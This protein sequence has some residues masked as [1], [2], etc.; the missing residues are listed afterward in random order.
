MRDSRHR[1]ASVLAAAVLVAGLAGDLPGASAG[2]PARRPNLVVIVLDDLGY[3]DLGCYGGEIRTPNIDRVAADGMRFARFYN[4]SRCCPTRAALLTGLYPHQVNLGSNGRDLGRNGATIAEL[5][6]AAGYRT[7]MAGKWHL[8]STTPLGGK[9]RGAGH[10]AWLNHHANLDRPFADVRTYPVNRGFERHFGPIWGVVDHFD[11]F[12]LV[13]G[14]EPVKAVP[15]GFYLTDAITAK[16]VEYIRTMARDDRP[17]FLYVAHCAPH[18]PLHAL[19]EDIA[20]YRDTYRGGWDAL[21]ASRYR[22]Q[23]EMGLV[24]PATHPLPPLDGRGPDW[25]AMDDADR[26]H[27]AALMAVHA[28][29]V[30]RVDQGVGAIVRALEETGRADDTLLL[31][32][33]DNG[34][35]PERYLNP[36]FDRATETR[37]GRPIRYEGRF[38]PGPETTWG[39]I[40][41]RW[42]SAANTPFHYWKAESFEGGCHGP[43]VVR[44]PNGLKAPRG[45][46]SRS[47]AHVI[48]LMPTCLDLAGVPYPGRYDGHVLLPLEGVSL[49][50]VL[51][52]GPA[53]TGR[54]LFFE[55]EGGRA[56]LS[57][58]WKAVA[59]PRGRWELYHIESDATE[60]RDLAA[61]ERARLAELTAS[62]RAWAGRVGAAIPKEPTGP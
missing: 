26:D 52:G 58:G 34:A 57:G 38:E 18:W 20:R 54:S 8:S 27:A 19:P 17:F 55:H 21:R 51:E 43:L 33:A 5:L 60:T 29:M 42:A 37:D 36:G 25:T 23:V 47:I 15:P 56:V 49:R 12:S 61:A 9:E 45:T 62:W 11:P 16:S 31:V 30:D 46:I 40:G 13:E 39:Y 2:A 6:R 44:W 1:A 32:L 48:D 53:A 24:D 22:R 35:S 7:A 28:A 14:T 41:P 50:P 3:S 10:M 59:H 4:A